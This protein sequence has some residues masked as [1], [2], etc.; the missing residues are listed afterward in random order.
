MDGLDLG[1]FLAQELW[2]QQVRKRS[3]RGGPEWGLH[4]IPVKNKPYPPHLFMLTTLSVQIAL[5]IHRQKTLVP[6]TTN[7]IY[8]TYT[9]TLGSLFSVNTYKYIIRNILDSI[10]CLFI[11]F[12][13]FI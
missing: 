13:F 7:H 12:Y 11:I 6:S 3:R 4:C 5:R 1:H 9:L 8:G 10:I 2:Y